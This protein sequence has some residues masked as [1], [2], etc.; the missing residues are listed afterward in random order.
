MTSLDERDVAQEFKGAGFR[1][2]RLNRRLVS[3]G[4]AIGREPGLSL[5][6]V[7]SGAELEAAYR[8]LSNVK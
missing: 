3:L 6:R 4:E 2:Q 5:P 8:F 7:L 1:D